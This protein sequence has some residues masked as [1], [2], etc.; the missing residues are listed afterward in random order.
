VETFDSARNY[1]EHARRLTSPAAGGNTQPYV[2]HAFFEMKTTKGVQKGEYS[3]TW[4]SDSQ[5]CREAVILD[6]RYAR[7]RNGEKW[8]LLATGPDSPAL[9]IVLKAIEPIPAA[10]TFVESDWRINRQNIGG[11]SLVRVATG[12]ES[13]EG[14]LDARSRGLWFDSDGLLVRSHFNGLDTVQFQF[15][16]FHGVEIPR[17]IRILSNG[18]LAMHIDITGIEPAANLPTTAFTLAGHEWKR[19]F[20]DEAR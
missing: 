4:L 11:R 18:Q 3:D 15:Q 17:H 6:S 16:D 9:Q 12:H 1:F 14:V 2:L 13:N 19:Q 10:D 7:C 8:Y 20:T 5:W